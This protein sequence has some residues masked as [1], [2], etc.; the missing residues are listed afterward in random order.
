MTET[1]QLAGEIAAQEVRAEITLPVDLP[2]TQGSAFHATLVLTGDGVSWR[3][4][5]QTCAESSA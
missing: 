1:T 2:N 3:F 5:L 4:A